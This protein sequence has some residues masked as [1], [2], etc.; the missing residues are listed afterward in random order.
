MSA[1]RIQDLEV[2]GLPEGTDED[3]QLAIAF[4]GGDIGAY[5]LIYAR[6]SKRVHGV[7]RRM[8]HQP[9]DAAEAAQETFL[10]I[11][12][13]LPRFNGRYQLGAWITRIATN[14][15]LDYLRS[16]TRKPSD[17]FD[18]DE[19]EQE[20]GSL[21]D[22][23]P[24]TIYIRNAEG[25][26]VRAILQSLPPLH[27]AAIVLRDFE[28]L[29]YEEVAAVLGITDSQ[30]KALIHRA[31]RGFKRNWIASAASIF[32]PTRLFQRFRTAD[33]PLREQAAS[34]GQAISTSAPSFAA[35]CNGA[36]QQCG[37]MM[38][39]K[40]ASVAT[41]VVVGAAAISVVT[42]P[43]S[44]AGSLVQPDNSPSSSGKEAPSKIAAN[45]RHATEAVSAEEE[46]ASQ[47]TEVPPEEEEALAEP[48]PAPEPTGTAPPVEP[49]PEP[50]ATAGTGAEQTPSPEPSP[51]EA[52]P[53]PQGHS[54]G[55]YQDA[56]GPCSGCGYQEEV[57][58]SSASSSGTAL[59]SFSERLKGTTSGGFGVELSHSSGDMS[60]HN[61]SFVLRTEEGTYHYSAN[62][63]LV[64]RSSTDWGG[65]VYEFSGSYALGSRPSSSEAVP[66]RGSYR[67]VITFSHT[68]NRIVAT[69]V[70]LTES[71]Q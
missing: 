65:W 52:P 3:K 39:D 13:S 68:Q 29:P 44:S 55:F 8:L 71:G 7:C 70:S 63:M 15:C 16:R 42:V 1:V 69:S 56:G 60:G 33:A 30:V 31:R 28:G 17:P 21:E 54:F 48:T 62:G 19:I 10:R 40:A 6:H 57:T 35:T 5:D 53:E 46:K 45:S 36:L 58:S 4:K 32:I 18:M 23:D 38:I 59:T 61:M 24:L 22:V 9:E 20:L 2:L 34:V 41:A 12:K 51:T 11:Y 27:R 26:R 50:T 66:E 25:R 43:S 47:L 64:G 14:V 49:E 37:S 67:A